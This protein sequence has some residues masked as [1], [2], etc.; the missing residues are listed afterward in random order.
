MAEAEGAEYDVV[1]SLY[2][3]CIP[4][5]RG[6]RQWV[7]AA[8]VEGVG[9]WAV[10][11]VGWCC[12][13]TVSS[14]YPFKERQKA[15]GGGGNGGRRWVV[16]GGGGRIVLYPHCILTVSPLYPH[17]ILTVSSLYP[18]KERCLRSPASG[19]GG[20]WWVVTVAAEGDGGGGWR[21]RRVALYPHCILTVSPLYPHCIPPKRG[22]CGGKEGGVRRKDEEEA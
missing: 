5:K 2:P 14:L 8:T 9:W 18:S 13:L 12:I 10:A 1:S 16:G 15:V 3:H 20:G 19:K 11:A 6:R 4:S 22:V 7:A 17:C 21:R